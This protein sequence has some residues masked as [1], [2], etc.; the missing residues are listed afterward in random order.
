MIKKRNQKRGG[1]FSRGGRLLIKTYR[2][3]QSLKVRG[4]EDLES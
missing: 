4:K 3:F 1:L 2:N